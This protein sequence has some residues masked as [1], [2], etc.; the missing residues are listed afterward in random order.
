MLQRFPVESKGRRKKLQEVILFQ[1]HKFFCL[2]DVQSF[3]L[4]FIFFNYLLT[5]CVCV[6]LFFNDRLAMSQ[7][8]VLHVF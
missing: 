5:F 1:I 7:P 4:F 6:F 8:Y 3:V 2:L